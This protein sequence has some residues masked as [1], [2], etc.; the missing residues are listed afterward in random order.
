MKS[1]LREKTVIG[2][3]GHHRKNKCDLLGNFAATPAPNRTN[4]IVL[5]NTPNSGPRTAT[6][7]PIIS[8]CTSRLYNLL[9]DCQE[10]CHI[11]VTSIVVEL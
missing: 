10:I 7:F 5:I 4:T 8:R 3:I 11:F 1:F 6:L 9:L 2:S